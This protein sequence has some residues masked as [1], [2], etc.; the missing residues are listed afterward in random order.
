MQQFAL[1]MKSK[2]DKESKD[3]DES[4]C[5]VADDDIKNLTLKAQKITQIRLRK[6]LL[7]S[8]K[9]LTHVIKQ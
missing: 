7:K 6:Q 5:I 3:N 1:E 2:D 8:M 9:I 4:N